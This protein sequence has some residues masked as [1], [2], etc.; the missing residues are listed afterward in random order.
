MQIAP[1]RHNSSRTIRWISIAGVIAALVWGFLVYQALQSHLADLSRTPVP[2][3]TTVEVSQPQTLT[4]FYEDPTAKGGFVVQSSKTSTLTSTP[5]DLEVTGPSGVIAASP[6]QRDLRFRYDGR[7]VIAM[8]T[9]EAPTAGTYA[10][11]VTGNSPS[12]AFVSV[13]NVAGSGL[14]ASFVGA[15]VLFLLSLAAI[16]LAGVVASNRRSMT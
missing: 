10:I 9:I 1:R 14:M 6:Y 13:G 12:G 3:K 11:L 5:V 7:A 16:A 2:G 4:I 15:V 8:A